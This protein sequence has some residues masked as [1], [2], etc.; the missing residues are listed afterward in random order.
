MLK[1]LFCLL[2]FFVF[3]VIPKPA[4]AADEF[5]S[6]YDI[7][8]S[9]LEDGATDV[10]QKIK[11]KNL[12]DKFFPSSF[13]LV[14]PGS[15]VSDITASDTQGNLE[16]ETSKEGSGTK[17]T[18]KFTNQQIIGVGKE[19]PFTLR[20]KDKGIAKNLGEVWNIK[21]P[22]IAQQTQV[23]GFKLVLSVPTS[24]GDPDYVL[25][26]PSR[27][28]ESG[29]RI[30]FSFAGDEFFQSG[31][32]AI[33][34]DK[35]NFSFEALY[36]LRNDSIFPKFAGIPISLKSNSQKTYIELIE[37]RPES[38]RVDA[39][40]NTIVF[41]KLNPAQTLD[42]KVSGFITTSL[43]NSEKEV[44]NEAQ[45]QTYLEKNKYW[46]ENNPIVKAKLTEILGGKENLSDLEKAR[47]IDK[48]VSNFLRF[49]YSRIE[50]GDFTRFGSLTSLNNP[51]KALA[52]E[53]VDLEI[54][55]LRAAGIPARQVIGFSLA[56]E[57]KPFSFHNPTLH[58]WVEIYDKQLGWI[59]SDPAWENTTQGT[60][61][62]NFN[63]LTHLGL[64]YGSWNSGYI[65][66]SKIE[67]KIHQG[68]IQE[69]KGAEL[70]V[71]INPEILSGFPAKAKIR[72]NN[73]GNVTFPA[74]ELKILTSK[75]LIEQD[76]GEP[77]IIVSLPTPEIPPFGNVEYDFDLKTGAIWHSYQDA[78]QVEFAGVTDTRIISVNPILSYKI[79]AIE[80][81]GGLTIIALFYLMVL[82]IHHKSTRKG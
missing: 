80:I 10:T 35:L 62:F 58:S 34:G 79:F 46:D 57:G 12:T 60:E 81:F 44:L 47:E 70:D 20:M 72:I 67:A 74:S 42:V 82:L 39:F 19:Y 64:T 13:S 7:T 29:G 27:V 66:P 30:N 23:E 51:E 59:I 63:D 22:K 52:A 2:L 45:T 69:K 24:F 15:E 32:S 3:W 14:V 76:G 77:S 9:V 61:L 18:V 33:F 41:F 56:Q 50:K 21:I 75:I 37:P 5:S 55:L 25:P 43:N 31:V 6:S 40:G 36:R 1:V 28:S 71:Q 78:F 54:T 73:L 4:F 68:E 38:S 16:V 53:F 65:L 17:L 11:L 49:D 26:K 8:Y 48:Y